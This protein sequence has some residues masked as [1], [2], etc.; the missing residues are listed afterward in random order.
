[1]EVA[2]RWCYETPVGNLYGVRNVSA[3]VGSDAD[4]ESVAVN[5]W[6]RRVSVRTRK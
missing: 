3:I 1:M 5:L 2:E 4:D 6:N